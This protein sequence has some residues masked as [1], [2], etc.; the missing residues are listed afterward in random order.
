MDTPAVPVSPAD[1]AELV[2]R[3]LA[4]SREAFGLIVGRYQSL[5]CA[6]TFCATGSVSR[7]QDLAQDTF[8]AAWRQLAELREP[9]KLRGWLCGI[10]RNLINADRRRLGREPAHRAETF[11]G[12][13][14][15]AAEDPSPPAKVISAEE[16]ALLWREVGRLPEIY[17]EPMVLY[18]REER[19][20]G[21]V[22]EALGLS[23]EAV[24]QRLSRG[25]KMLHER[26]LIFVEDALGR[27]K[28]GRE[29][30]LGVQAALPVLVAGGQ[31]AGLASAKGVALKGG[32]GLWAFALQ[33]AGM[34]AAIGLTR[35]HVRQAPNPRERRFAIGWN[36]VLWIS[37][38]VLVLALRG[39]ATLGESWQWSM[40]RVIE[41]SV[42][43]W[44]GY[45]MIVTTLLVVAY[46]RAEAEFRRRA[47]GGEPPPTPTHP[48]AE[49]IGTYVA[50]TAW[51]IGLACLM[52]DGGA[53]LLITVF[54][55]AL[56]AWNLREMRRRTGWEAQKFNFGCHAVLCGWLLFAANLRVA[57]WTAPLFRVPVGEMRALLSL[58]TV[59]LL[60]VVLA[61]WAGLLLGLTRR[62]ARA[63]T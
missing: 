34:L 29:F 41:A 13:G 1:D 44:F 26:M 2:A 36:L 46:R 24:M 5:V 62:F 59:H 9:A 33:L 57:H 23:E 43:I 47:V 16:M 37:I 4:G 32:G 7:S 15:L 40:R 25:R 55:V 27:T 18:Y 39:V 63:P 45:L 10:A 61:A 21:R 42:W 20:V 56:A 35:E 17:R 53:A 31:G 11:D 54:T 28:P 22:A 50:S 6:L 12:T 58:E 3:S 30:M 19:S 51:I 14:K 52:G 8:V 60:T 49:L 48:M 38:G